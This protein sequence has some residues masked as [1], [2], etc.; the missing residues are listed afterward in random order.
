MMQ[1]KMEISM[2]ILSVLH[3]VNSVLSTCTSA[4]EWPFTSKSEATGDVSVVYA[5]F[6]I[7]H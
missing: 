7:I 4:A 2:L 3:K 1:L 6:P 5:T